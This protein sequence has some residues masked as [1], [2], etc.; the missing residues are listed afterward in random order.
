[1]KSNSHKSKLREKTQPPTPPA[2]EQPGGRNEARGRCPG[3]PERGQDAPE[4]RASGRDDTAPERPKDEG[5]TKPLGQSCQVDPSAA[6]PR[7]AC[8]SER[9]VGPSAK[10]LPRHV[11]PPWEPGGCLERVCVHPTEH[12]S[13]DA[14][15]SGHHHRRQGQEMASRTAGEG[16]ARRPGG[17]RQ[18]GPLAPAAGIGGP[19]ATAAGD[20]SQGQTSPSALPLRAR[21]RVAAGRGRG[22]KRSRRSSREGTVC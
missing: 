5:S 14:D 21:R 22:T 10:G 4:S 2:S 9:G 11:P 7:G 8:R 20:R 17:G 18:H 3:R 13:V 16:M 6:S 1:M 12:G 15:A 19:V